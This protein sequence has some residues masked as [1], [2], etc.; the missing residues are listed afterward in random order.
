VLHRKAGIR[1]ATDNIY[2]YIY[3]G[4]FKSR[5][6]MFF[7][8]SGHFIYIYIYAHTS[9]FLSA[10]RFVIKFLIL[11]GHLIDQGHL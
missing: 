7:Y 6:L 4:S 8:S 1:K 5:E 2:I 9:Y 11:L 3:F 10:K